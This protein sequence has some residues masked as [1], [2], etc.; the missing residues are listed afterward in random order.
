M[1]LV[2]ALIVFA[3]LLAAWTP[4][5]A[6]IIQGMQGRYLLLPALLASCALLPALPAP[7]MGRRLI[8]WTVL[9]IFAMLSLV[10]LLQVLQARYGA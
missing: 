4:H 2:S 8:P 10:L 5:P 6:T 3:A 7:A 9:A 1:A